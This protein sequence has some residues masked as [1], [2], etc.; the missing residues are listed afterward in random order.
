MKLI[1]AKQWVEKY[2]DEGSRPSEQLLG[3]WCREGRIPCRKVAGQWYVD[4]HMW[5][6]GD[7]ELVASVLAAV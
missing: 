3:R 7:D 1:L 5:V 2:F 6:A 4:E